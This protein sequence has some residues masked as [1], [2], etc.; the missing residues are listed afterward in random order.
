MRNEVALARRRDFEEADVIRPLLR[1]LFRYKAL[2]KALQTASFR[3][4][5][6]TQMPI[7]E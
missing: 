2:Q 4:H 7:S 1:E 5:P 3:E 6:E